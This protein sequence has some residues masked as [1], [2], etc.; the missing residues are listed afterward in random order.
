MVARADLE[1]F[2]QAN[3]GL[4]RLVIAELEAFFR[5]LDLNKPEAVRNALLE[6]VPLLTA[7]YGDVAETLALEW[8]EDLA[9]GGVRAVAPPVA[10]PSVA[11]E[12][13]VRRTAGHL[14]TPTPEAMLAALKVSVDKFVKQPG[15]DA[16]AYNAD[17]DGLRWARVPTGAKT[18][19]WCLVLAS[20][21]AVYLT[22]KLAGTRKDGGKYHGDCDCVPTPIQS[23]DDYPEGYD[24][25]GMYRM[26]Q[27]ARESAGSAEMEDIAASMRRLYPD[28]VKDG[29]HEH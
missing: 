23:I 22:E 17:R 18:C 8:Y 10:V 3:I 16:I 24:P 21:D 26:Y 14:W 11:V 5:S 7:Q 4:S 27:E 13:T 9:G 2:R 20:R 28:V 1:R 6:F 19:S 29:A 15:R 12:T 25:D